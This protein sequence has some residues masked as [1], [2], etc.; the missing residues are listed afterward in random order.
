MIKPVIKARRK[1]LKHAYGI[2]IRI[3]GLEVGKAYVVYR[4]VDGVVTYRSGHGH[5]S[6]LEA[7]ERMFENRVAY[8]ER[9]K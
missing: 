2:G 8:W 7:S 6:G 5:R 9:T 4:G 3:K 1:W